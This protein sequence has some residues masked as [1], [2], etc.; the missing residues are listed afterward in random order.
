MWS[1]AAVPWD[2]A[3]PL[4]FCAP[5][6]GHTYLGGERGRPKIVILIK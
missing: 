4:L 5:I 6:I 2:G 3:P 1:Y